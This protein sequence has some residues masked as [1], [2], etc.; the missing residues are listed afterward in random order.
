[1]ALNMASSVLLDAAILAGTAMSRLAPLL[2]GDSH[3]A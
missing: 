1:M 2:A 3:V